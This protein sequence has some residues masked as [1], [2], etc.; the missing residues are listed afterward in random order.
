M[1]FNKPPK[2]FN[3]R[4]TVVSIFME[5]D[6]RILLLKRLP[7]KSQ[8]GKWGLPAGK[9]DPGEDISTAIQRE[10]KEETGL[11]VSQ[12]EFAH[13]GEFYV[14]Y[15]DYDFVYHVFH[16]NFKEKPLVKIKTDEHDNYQWEIPARA[17]RSLNL[18]LGAAEIIKMF[19]K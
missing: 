15:P 9:V 7:N 16:I 5:S 6:G 12:K 4:F 1:I 11:L 10:I 18:M 17:E 2:N 8:G 19:Y 13:W 3:S 14:R